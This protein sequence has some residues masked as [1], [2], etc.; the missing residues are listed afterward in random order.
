[1]NRLQPG[2]LRDFS[3]GYHPREEPKRLFRP[4]GA[5]EPDDPLDDPREDPSPLLLGLKQD[6]HDAL[7]RI[8]GHTLKGRMH[9][10]KILM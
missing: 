8:D 9:V 5:A 1:M 3:R 6:L 7:H 4:G 10:G 2:G